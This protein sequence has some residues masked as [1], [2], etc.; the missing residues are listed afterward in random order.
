MGTIC[1]SR[2]G[3]VEVDSCVQ[4]TE[5]LRKNRMEYGVTIRDLDRALW[6]YDYDRR[7]NS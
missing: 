5:F 4:T 2:M 3:Q 1:V 6:A 7:V